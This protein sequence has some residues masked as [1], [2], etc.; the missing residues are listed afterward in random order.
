MIPK[1]VQT[2]MLLL[3]L[4]IAFTNQVQPFPRMFR[5]QLQLQNRP[6][7]G[8]ASFSTQWPLLRGTANDDTRAA[9]HLFSLLFFTLGRPAKKK[10][11]SCAKNR[12]HTQSA[13]SWG[14]TGAAKP[15]TT[16]DGTDTGVGDDFH[17]GGTQRLVARKNHDDGDRD[18]LRNFSSSTHHH[19]T[20]AI[21]DFCSSLCASCQTLG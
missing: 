6:A 20:A 12:C 11:S 4:E 3:L 7:A 17:D 18:R 13:N 16:D 10:S 2:L 8:T 1:V 9:R 15:A 5:D 19:D 14:N 21:F